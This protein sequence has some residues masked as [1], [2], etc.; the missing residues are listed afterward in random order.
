VSPKLAVLAGRGPLPAAVIQAAR[1]SGREVFVLAFEGET[2]PGVVEGV[3]HR[4]VSLGAV[5]RTVRTLH[6]VG[7]EEVC[8]IG[9]VQRPSL[10]ALKLDLRGMQLLARLGVK[11]AGDDRLFKV[12]VDELESEGF[13]VVGADEVVDALVAP[14]GVIGRRAPDARAWRDVELGVEIASRLGEL[15]IGQAVVVQQGLVL[16]VEAV[17]GTDRLLARCGELRRDGP[18]GVLVKLKKPDQER[19]ADL[20]TI[21]PATVKGAAAAGLSGIAVQ[22]GHCLIVDRPATVAAADDSGLFL[23]GVN[24]PG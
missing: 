5:G 23:L 2:D 20:P 1:D 19:R 7:A 14:E 8:L 9:P 15:D 12:I 4:W 13:R 17:E 11:G 22:A 10:T 3:P 24:G 18:G 21:G 16:G 6:D